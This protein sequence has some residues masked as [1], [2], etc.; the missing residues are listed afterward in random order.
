M[1]W[2]F[3]G[4]NKPNLGSIYNNFAIVKYFEAEGIYD[5]IIYYFEMALK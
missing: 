2:N 3:Y 4:K 1:N 5:D